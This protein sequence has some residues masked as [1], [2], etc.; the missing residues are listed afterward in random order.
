MIDRW[1]HGEISQTYR[2]GVDVSVALLERVVVPPPPRHDS[3]LLLSSIFLSTTPRAQPLLPPRVVA[4]CYS[5]LGW[6]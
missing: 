3:R 5:A 4:F 2:E 6:D 1:S